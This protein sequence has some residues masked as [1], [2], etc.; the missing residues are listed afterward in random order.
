MDPLAEDKLLL[1]FLGRSL[2][3][4]QMERARGAGLDQFVM[5]A[6]PQNLEKIQRI[7][8]RYPEVAVDFAVQ[9]MPQGI[10]HAVQQAEHLLQDRVLLV[11]SNDVFDSAAYASLLSECNRN[12][13][14]AYVLGYKVQDYFP[15]GYLV[16]GKEGSLEQ[17]IEK[18]PKGHEPSNLVNIMVHLHTDI[19]KLLD[20][21]SR[22]E[23][24]ADDVYECALDR[25]VGDGHHIR[26]IPYSGF[27]SAIKYPWHIFKIVRYFLDTAEA[28][29]SS[30]ARI[31]PAATVEGK[32]II[33]DNV[34]IMENAVIKGP[35]Y[36]GS[37][38]IIGTNALVREYSHVGADCVVGYC[39]E[40][41]GSYIGDRCW[42]HS[43][44]VGDSIL[45]DGCSFGAGTVLANFRFDEQNIMVRVGDD[46]VD[47]GLD[48]LGAMVGENAKT[49]INTSVLPGIRIGA[50]CF[51]GPHVCLTRDVEANKMVLPESSYRVLGKSVGLD[52]NKKDE[53]MK[54][55][56]GL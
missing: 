23:T 18:P 27:W 6:N 46:L 24:S 9:E 42:F 25:M 48:K 32:V 51:I 16:A 22:V 44:Y 11:N 21:I 39:T 54:R 34:R 56:E 47:T 20:Y 4:H 26:V 50:N 52:S 38:T 36:I 49:G 2:L 12:S 37:N 3:E 19:A 29:I 10:A 45:G 33:E 5:V 35:V 55:L 8:S 30:S 1:K 41:K 14:V 7:V 17:I 53:L 43:S 28:G 13:A 40:V 15:G 31:S